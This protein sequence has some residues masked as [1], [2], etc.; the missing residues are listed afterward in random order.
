VTV[1]LFD[2]RFDN[3]VGAVRRT[4]ERAVLSAS[5]R[6]YNMIAG[7]FPPFLHGQSPQIQIQVHVHYDL[8]TKPGTVGVATYDAGPATV[9]HCVAPNDDLEIAAAIQ[10]LCAS[11]AALLVQWLGS[12]TLS[13]ANKSCLGQ[14]LSLSIARDLYPNAVNVF[15]PAEESWLTT[16]P[17]TDYVNKPA[18]DNQNSVANGCVMLFLSFLRQMGFGWHQIIL[19]GLPFDSTPRG[20][21]QILTKDAADPFPAFRAAVSAEL[22]R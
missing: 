6:D 21:Y 8:Q 18:E 20:I 1:G 2:I 9:F 17:L 4:I 12:S 14:G 5:Q 16:W 15:G 22:R 7:L 19:A 13:W 10:D 3:D 11:V